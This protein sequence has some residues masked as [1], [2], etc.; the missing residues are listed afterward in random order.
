MNAEP[1][2][3]ETRRA[4]VQRRRAWAEASIADLPG[5]VEKRRGHGRTAC[6]VGDRTDVTNLPRDVTSISESLQDAQAEPQLTLFGAGRDWFAVGN[7]AP[8]RRAAFDPR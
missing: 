4:G 5:Q 3:A 8:A 7:P 6:A 1:R 2:P